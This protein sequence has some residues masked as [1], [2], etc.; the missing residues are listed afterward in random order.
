MFAKIIWLFY[1]KIIR[2]ASAFNHFMCK[3]NAIN[4][5]HN[6]NRVLVEWTISL[7]V[8]IRKSIGLMPSNELEYGF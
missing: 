6:F 1:L 2:L 3:R 7:N 8:E 5:L 4:C